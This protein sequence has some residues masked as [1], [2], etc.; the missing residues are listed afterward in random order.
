MFEINSYILQKMGWTKYYT[1]YGLGPSLANLFNDDNLVRFFFIDNNKKL[2]FI[3][4]E[5]SPDEKQKT[6]NSYKFIQFNIPLQTSIIDI[7]KLKLQVKNFNSNEELLKL[8]IEDEAC[9][10]TYQ[11]HFKINKLF[12]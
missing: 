5:M 8:V 10:E 1:S 6:K 4:K 12:K 9:N 2:C 11:R 3:I 7:K